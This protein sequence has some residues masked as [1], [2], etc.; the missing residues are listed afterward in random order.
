MDLLDLAGQIYYGWV[1]LIQI[2]QGKL[3]CEIIR[4]YYLYKREREHYV[5]MLEMRLCV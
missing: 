2:Y 4:E 3:A 1:H 5:G